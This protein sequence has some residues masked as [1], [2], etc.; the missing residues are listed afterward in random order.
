MLAALHNATTYMSVGTSVPDILA[1]LADSAAE[2]LEAKSVAIGTRHEREALGRP[3]LLNFDGAQGEALI[4]FAGAYVAELPADRRSAAIIC[5]SPCNDRRFSEAGEAMQ[6]IRNLLISPFVCGSYFTGVLLACN[7]ST[8]SGFTPAHGETAELLASYVEVLL[9]VA[10]L[11][12]RRCDSAGR[13]EQRRIAAELHDGLLQILAS[14]DLRL[15]ASSRLWS[16]AQWEALGEELILLKGLAEEALREVRGAINQIAPAR[17]REEGLIAHLKDCIHR[18]QEGTG[19]SVDASLDLV[20][21]AVPEPTALLLIA[22][23]REGLNNIRKHARASR[24]MLSIAGGEDQITLRL[25]DDGLG[26]GP[27]AWPRSSTPTSHYGLASLHERIARVGGEL[28]VTGS[29]NAG[30][31]LEARVPILTEA[32]LVSLLFSAA[33]ESLRSRSGLVRREGED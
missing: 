15:L 23:V 21:R 31:V 28:R 22:L 19:V 17:L 8:G 9:E 30:T 6:G 29:P 4:D 33:S 3:I 2:L 16:G 20:E 12:Q 5:N 7:R 11:Q 25:A 24:V 27:E 13:D 10:C 18:F 26:F 14:L 1:R 32:R